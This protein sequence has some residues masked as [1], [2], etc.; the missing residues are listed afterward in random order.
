M[1]DL[2]KK[3]KAGEFEEGDYF[4]VKDKDGNHIIYGKS[5]DIFEANKIH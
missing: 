4:Y 5:E 2:T 1:T 3:W